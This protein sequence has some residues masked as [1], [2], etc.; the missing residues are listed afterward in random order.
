MIRRAYVELCCNGN[1]M[2][3]NAS[4][5]IQCERAY[6]PRWR[7]T[8]RIRVNG[9]VSGGERRPQ[10]QKTYLVRGQ[11]DRIGWARMYR[12]DQNTPPALGAGAAEPRRMQARVDVRVFHSDRWR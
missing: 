1:V 12:M 2:L 7:A 9:A 10:L 4:L 3:Q 11:L 6:S 5:V 8:C